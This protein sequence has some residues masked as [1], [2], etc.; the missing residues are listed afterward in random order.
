MP[1]TR[2][3]YPPEF[4]RRIVDLVSKGRTP[5]ELAPQF[6]PSAQAIRNWVK[7]LCDDWHIPT[8]FPMVASALGLRMLCLG[9]L[10]RPSRCWSKRP[11]TEGGTQ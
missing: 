5:E 7:G 3:P 10:P 11:R 6:E 8:L 9:G 4:R 2:P 1:K